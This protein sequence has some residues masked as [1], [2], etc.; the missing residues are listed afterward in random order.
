MVPRVLVVH[1]ALDV[2]DVEQCVA[3]DGEAALDL[4]A[5]HE[6]DAVVLDLSRPPLDGWCVLA[7]IGPR[8]FG[9]RERL[10]RV[11]ARL[12]DRAD[13]HRALA[14]GADLCVMAGTSLH[15]RALTP[16]WQRHRSTNSPRPTRVGA[17]A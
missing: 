2:D 8:P 5:R 3:P 11:I 16:A 17:S 1:D 14:L 4:L 9:N 12:G 7:A 6:F 10:P 15:A 13:A